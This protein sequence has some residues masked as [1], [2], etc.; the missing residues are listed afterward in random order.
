MSCGVE[1]GTGRDGAGGRW[2]VDDPHPMGAC[3]DEF[4]DG[5]GESADGRHVEDGIRVLAV[6]EAALGE[7]D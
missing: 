3:C 7:D 5:V 1:A 2:A 6:V 4:R